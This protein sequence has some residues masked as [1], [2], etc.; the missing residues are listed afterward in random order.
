MMYNLYPVSGKL[1]VFVDCYWESNFKDIVGEC[2][3]ELFVAQLNPNIIVN[4]SDTYVRN[5]VT[6]GQSAL[7]TINTAAI[8][9]LHQA[10]N[11]LFGIRF[12]PAG[13][14]MF[15]SI[16]L[17]ELRDATIDLKDIFREDTERFENKM[18]ECK[19][20]KERIAVTESFLILKLIEKNLEKYKFSVAVQNGIVKYFDDSNCVSKVVE[21]LN[22]THRTFDRNFKNILG[23]SPKK[24]QRLIRFQKAFEMMHMSF[25][26]DKFFNF[27]M[28]GYFDQ[29]HF[30]KEFKEFVSMSPQK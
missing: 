30:S 15:T 5:N 2:Y 22:I 19:N 27:Y 14:V 16:G 18:F 3:S 17:D 13:L 28:F 20:T 25:Q 23:V 6:I 10:S 26:K 11:H 1:S 8:N 4:L 29:A 21:H 24:L 9:F 12:K 7:N